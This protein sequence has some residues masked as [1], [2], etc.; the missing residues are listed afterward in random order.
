[1]FLQIKSHEL[2]NA[3]KYSASSYILMGSYLHNTVT[4][5]S[6]KDYFY[7]YSDSSYNLQSYDYGLQFKLDLED[8]NFCESRI[9]VK[10]LLTG[11]SPAYF[12]IGIKLYPFLKNIFSKDISYNLIRGYVGYMKKDLKKLSKINIECEAKWKFASHIIR[13]NDIIKFLSGEIDIYPADHESYYSNWKDIKLGKTIYELSYL[14]SIVKQNI[15]KAQIIHDCIK[16][17]NKH[18]FTV[19]QSSYEE[20]LLRIANNDPE[21]DFSKYQEFRDIRYNTLENGLLSSYI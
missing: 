12:E 4:E 19:S 16:T 20:I 7:I 2:F 17:S 10:S 21:N 3:L 15:D 18:F 6:D 13:Q 5:K 11:E 8:H 14:E 9:F 1:M